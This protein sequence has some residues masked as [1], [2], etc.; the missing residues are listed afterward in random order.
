MKA[1]T[2]EQ[3]QGSPLTRMIGEMVVLDTGTPIVYLGIL[4]EVTDRELRLTGADLHDCRDGHATTEMY[5]AAAARQGVEIN[6]SEIIVMRS[7]VISVS[8][9]ADVVDQ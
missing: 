7:V 9:L 6:R 3:S 2:H 1:D 4:E 5:V 8:R